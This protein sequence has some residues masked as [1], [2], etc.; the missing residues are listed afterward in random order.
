[1]IKLRGTFIDEITH[2]I[3]SQNWTEDEWA[4]D[5][6]AMKH[7]GIDTV[8]LIRAGYKKHAVFASDVLQKRMGIYPVYT[9]L[10]DLFLQQAERCG[11]QLFFGLYDSGTHWG[12]KKDYAMEL[13]VNREFCKEVVDRYGHYSAFKGWY[14]S[15]E[16]SKHEPG[17]LDL[18]CE[19]STFLKGL[20]DQSVLISPYVEGVKQFGDQAISFEDHI[21]QWREIFKTLKGVVDI[22]AFQDGQIPYEE[23]ST[24]LKA[25]KALADEVGIESW[26]NVE[27]F[28]R[29]MPI[30][31]PPLPFKS[32]RYKMEQAA[33]AGIENLITFEFSNFMSPNSIYPSAHGMY[34]QYQNWL[35][36]QEAM[37]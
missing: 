22:V 28:D 20:K 30:K 23:L 10:M 16:I 26:S 33:K 34:K 12:P 21:Q 15:H 24:Y 19:M 37:Q 13:A 31:F 29:D 8:I 14:L 7:V 35:E 6:D 25:H 27:S 36:Q 18:Y 5:F 17:V 3:P 4:R 1:M 9:N 2:D 11:M 32:L